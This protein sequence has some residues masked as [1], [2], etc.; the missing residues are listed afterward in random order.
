MTY[1]NNDRPTNNEKRW[2]ILF[3][4]RSITSNAEIIKDFTEIGYNY[5]TVNKFIL[6]HTSEIN[7]L[8]QS[9]YIISIFL[10]VHMPI[11]VY[12]WYKVWN[13]KNVELYHKM[14]WLPER[15]KNKWKWVKDKNNSKLSEWKYNIVSELDNKKEDVILDVSI[16]YPID[17]R[18][19]ILDADKKSYYRIELIP[20]KDNIKRTEFLQ[21]QYQLEDF[22][23]H[24]KQAFSEIDTVFWANCKVHLFLTVPNP[25]SFIIGQSIHLNWP[26][27]IIY[28]F[29]KDKRKYE[30]ILKINN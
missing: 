25:F 3:L 21:H 1:R 28:D 23:E 17:W 14:Q 10:F 30:I 8:I 12:L 13:T 15:A 5:Q 19:T 4:K 7:K 22:R 24:I 9:N 2:A 26:E 16:S 11:A 27:V 20:L 29:D 18:N 6:E